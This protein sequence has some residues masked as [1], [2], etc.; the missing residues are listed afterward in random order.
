MLAPLVIDRIQKYDCQ[1]AVDYQNALLE[2]IQEVALFGLWRSKFFEH[3][4]FYG[5]TAL[6]ILYGLNRFSEDL[7]FSLL[8]HDPN[9]SLKPYHKSIQRELETLGFNVE[10]S[11]KQKK[12]ESTVRS[13]FIKGS[14]KEHLIKIGFEGSDKLKIPTNSTLKIK[15][16]IDIDPPDGFTTEPFPLAFPVPFSV[17]SYAP[18]S[19]F[20]GKMHALLFR[21]Y[22]GWVKGRDWYDYLWFLSNKIPLDLAHLKSRMCQTGHWHPDSDL[23]LE[24]VQKLF[25]ERVKALDAA[26]AQ[27][28]LKRF[29]SDPS[30]IDYW[31]RDYFLSTVDLIKALDE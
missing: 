6:R 2:I 19:M 25:T 21:D 18:P 5:G 9:F 22:S 26:S 15:F 16:E 23:K 30:Q 3:A 12:G 20:A 7:D 27:E 13:A 14:T 11:E 4:A 17:K 29:I 10:I 1:T 8:K 31:S 24:D 28:D